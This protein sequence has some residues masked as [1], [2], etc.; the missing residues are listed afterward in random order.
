VKIAVCG[1]NFSRGLAVKIERGHHHVGIADE[2][3]EPGGNE[4]TPPWS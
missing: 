4:R 3:T 2:V 1:D